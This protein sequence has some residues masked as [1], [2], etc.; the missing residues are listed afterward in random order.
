MSESSKN[1]LKP[2]IVTFLT[3][4]KLTEKKYTNINCIG[5]LNAIGIKFEQI[6]DF[7]GKYKKK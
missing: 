4:D 2:H 3:G 5:I 6:T 1:D 7:Y